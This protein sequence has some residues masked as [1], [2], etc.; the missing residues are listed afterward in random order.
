[1]KINLITETAMPDA[2][3]GEAEERLVL[4][5]GVLYNES[6]EDWAT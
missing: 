1:M 6:H 4:C 5:L 2:W 3:V